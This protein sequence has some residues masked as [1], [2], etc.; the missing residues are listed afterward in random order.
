MLRFST[1]FRVWWRTCVLHFRF[2]ICCLNCEDWE[3]WCLSVCYR[4]TLLLQCYPS[5]VFLLGSLQA[6]D[7]DHESGLTLAYPINVGFLL[8]RPTI[9]ISLSMAW[10]KRTVLWSESGQMRDFIRFLE[11][12]ATHACGLLTCLFFWKERNEW[13]VWP[14][15]KFPISVHVAIE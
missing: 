12:Y 1:A 6:R 7:L 3:T 14:L 13:C 5:A 9:L 15:W 10:I 2:C 4:F 11:D 8:V